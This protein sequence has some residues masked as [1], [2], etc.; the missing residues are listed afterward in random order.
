MATFNLGAQAQTTIEEIAADIR[1]VWL[2]FRL[3]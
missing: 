1:S 3:N 2:H